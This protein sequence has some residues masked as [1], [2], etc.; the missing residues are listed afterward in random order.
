MVEFLC[1]FRSLKSPT[2]KNP[3]F[4]LAKMF[5]TA[6]IPESSFIFAILSMYKTSSKVVR[7]GAENTKNTYERRQHDPFNNFN[8]LTE[9]LL[10]ILVADGT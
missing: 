4:N 3:T 2:G 5:K 7:F 10:T 1:L 9:V 6:E 8:D